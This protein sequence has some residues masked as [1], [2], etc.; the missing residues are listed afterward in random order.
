MSKD[1]ESLLTEL[2]KAEPKLFRESFSASVIALNCET[3]QKGLKGLKQENQMILSGYCL[4]VEGMT[5]HHK[6]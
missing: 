1:L 2:S 5:A 6:I 4:L 3:L